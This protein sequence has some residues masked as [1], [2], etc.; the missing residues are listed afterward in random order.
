MDG[1]I[2]TVREG[3]EGLL[4]AA[5]H[6]VGGM[7]PGVI[8]TWCHKALA[9][10]S[11]IDHEAIRREMLLRDALDRMYTMVSEPDF[12]TVP[13]KYYHHVLNANHVL[14]AD[15]AQDDGKPDAVM[16]M[17]ENGDMSI[18]WECSACKKLIDDREDIE[19]VKT[20]PHCGASIGDF[21]YIEETNE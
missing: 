21:L 20:C 5:N 2:D 11:A 4:E 18:S 15:P 7:V 16:A 6:N 1:N 17:I 3:I 14:S 8:A 9:A 13:N 19:A 10:L 12:P